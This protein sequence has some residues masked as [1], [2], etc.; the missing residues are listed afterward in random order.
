MIFTARP[1]DDRRVAAE[2]TAVCSVA[3]EAQ[4]FD[5]DLAYRLLR[6]SSSGRCLLGP[7]AAILLDDDSLGAR[8]LASYFCARSKQWGPS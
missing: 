1:S 8:L 3:I 2:V 5:L 7:L 6:A 4:F